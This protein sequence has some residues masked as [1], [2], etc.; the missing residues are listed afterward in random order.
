MPAM[1]QAR[2]GVKLELSTQSHL[3]VVGLV[4]SFFLPLT[5]LAQSQPELLLTV[6][7]TAAQQSRTPSPYIGSAMALLAT[8]EDAGVLPPEGTPQA[9]SIIKAVIQ[10]QSAFLKS[11]DPAVQHFFLEA[12][13]AKFGPRAEEIEASFRLTGWSADSFDAV[14]AAGH[15]ANAWNADGLVEAFREFNIGKL[16]FDLLAQ[17]YQQSTAALSTQGRTF[18]EVYAQR[19]REMPGAKSE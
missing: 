3:L 14:I 10:F 7:R 6:T 8:F 16:D 13:R 17:L 19:R 5:L 9:N 2:T 12:H 18:H 15:T 11:H 4:G 1:P